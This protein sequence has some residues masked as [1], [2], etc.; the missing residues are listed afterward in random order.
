MPDPGPLRHARGDRPTA[1]LTTESL[2]LNQ[3]SSISRRI[4]AFGVESAPDC[5]GWFFKLFSPESPACLIIDKFQQRLAQPAVTKHIEA[6]APSGTWNQFEFFW[7]TAHNRGFSLCCIIRKTFRG[8]TASQKLDFMMSRP[9]S[10]TACLK[11]R[12]R[13]TRNPAKRLFPAEKS[14]FSRWFC[15]GY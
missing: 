15:T 12:P 2:A 3:K 9:R 10:T 6:V 8:Q 1:S 7:I 14:F 4:F 11:P 13:T 5:K